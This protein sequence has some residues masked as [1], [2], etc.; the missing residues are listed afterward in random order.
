MAGIQ[1]VAGKQCEEDVGVIGPDAGFID[2]ALL[3]G[4]MAVGPSA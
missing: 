2:N 3:I 1:P 4:K